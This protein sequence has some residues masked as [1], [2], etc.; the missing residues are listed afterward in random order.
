MERCCEWLISR[1]QEGYANFLQLLAA[2]L[3]YLNH[4]VSFNVVRCSRTRSLSSIQ[5]HGARAR[6][7]YPQLL[8][9]TEGRRQ[10][11]LLQVSRLPYPEKPFSENRS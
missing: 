5:H 2:S 10:F 4:L 8:G 1:N 3:R 6:E 7:T 9:D 11:V